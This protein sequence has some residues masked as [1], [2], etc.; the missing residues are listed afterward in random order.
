MLNGIQIFLWKIFCK[1]H[2]L[3][4]FTVC[5]VEDPSFF[6]GFVQIEQ[7]FRKTILKPQLGSNYPKAHCTPVSLLL[8]LHCNQ[9]M[10]DGHPSK[11]HLSLSIPLPSLIRFSP[12]YE[13]LHQ[14]GLLRMNLSIPTPLPPQSGQAASPAPQPGVPLH[15]WEHA[16]AADRLQKFTFYAFFFVVLQFKDQ[17]SKSYIFSSKC[18]S[19]LI[20][21][22]SYCEPLGSWTSAYA[23]YKNYC[24]L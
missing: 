21:A 11:N 14:V 18:S 22:I 7:E 19:I 2:F 3:F 1:I 20:Q 12:A 23:S 24:S 4:C 5:L 8:S 16:S 6:P 10:L 17:H 9:D 15:G 13:V